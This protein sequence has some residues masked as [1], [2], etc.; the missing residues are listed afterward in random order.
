MANLAA[1][2]TISG[3]INVLNSVALTVSA[4]PIDGVT[5]VTN[6]GTAPVTIAP[7]DPGDE[8]PVVELLTFCHFITVL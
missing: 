2:N 4:A 6:V 8:R 1:T 7:E 5:G 3:A